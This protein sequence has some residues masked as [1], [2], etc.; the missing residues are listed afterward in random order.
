VNNLIIGGRSGIG[1]AF[2]E[3]VGETDPTEVWL[4]PNHVELDVRDDLALEEYIHAHQPFNKVVYSAGVNVLG[5]IGSLETR[6]VRRQIDVNLLGFIFFLD[7]L[8]RLNSTAANVLVIGSDAAERPL[9]ASIAYT[10]SKAG[11]HMAVRTAARELGAT[12]WKIN[13]L[14][15]GM[16]EPTRMQEYIDDAV[17]RMRR[18]TPEHAREY[19]RS[20]EVVPGRVHVSECAQMMMDI[21]NGPPHLNGSIIYLN[22]GR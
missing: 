3:M 21:L 14:A 4:A 17:P 13:C 9:R 10:A 15:P 12:G 19:E 1:L 11:L 20:Q 22:G 6:A 18:W 2:W 16:T 5:W 7:A 8:V